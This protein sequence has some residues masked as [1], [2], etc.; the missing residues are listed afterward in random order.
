MPFAR[1]T[2]NAPPAHELADDLSIRLT[3]LIALNLGKRHE[4]TSVLVEAPGFSR[5]MI[6]AREQPIAAHLEV[7]VTGGTNSEQ[8]KRSFVANAMEMLRK[9]L[10]GLDRA[11][12]IVVKEVAATDW[13]YDGRTQADRGKA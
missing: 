12:Y 7:C 5:W 3:E 8:E 4:L 2:L 6:G 13:G 9:A 10:P 1:L 11:T